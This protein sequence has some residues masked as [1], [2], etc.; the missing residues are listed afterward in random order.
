MANGIFKKYFSK[1]NRKIVI[2]W[3]D[4]TLLKSSE[5]LPGCLLLVEPFVLLRHYYY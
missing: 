4:R 5:Y 3:N 2:S 1:E